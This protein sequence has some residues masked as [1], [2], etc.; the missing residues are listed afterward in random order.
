LRANEYWQ[1]INAWVQVTQI[2]LDAFVR[3]QRNGGLGNQ[4][5]RRLS[6]SGCSIL[7]MVAAW[8]AGH[9]P[10]ALLRF[11]IPDGTSFLVAQRGNDQSILVRSEYGWWDDR[12]A[13]EYTADEIRWYVFDDRQMYRPGEEVHLKG[14]LRRGWNNRVM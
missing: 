14:W 9:P 7:P 5:E 6:G 1:T 4:P 10:T 11:P 8:L 2:G 12:L 3:S 13:G